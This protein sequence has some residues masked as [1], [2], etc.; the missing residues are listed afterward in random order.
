MRGFKDVTSLINFVVLLIIIT[1]L[2][3]ITIEMQE[4]KKEIIK[5]ELKRDTIVVKP[6][7]LSKNPKEGLEEA[8]HYYNISHKDIVLAQAILETGNFKSKVCLKYNNLFGLYNSKKKDYYKF[9]HWSHSVDFYKRNIQSKHKP[10]IDYYVFLKRINYAEDKNYTKNLKKIVND[11][12][13]N[14]KRNTEDTIS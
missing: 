13:K 10:P 12:R 9:D 4:V 2:L 6:E 3:H 7:F 14:I 1:V 8:L 11:K 5:I